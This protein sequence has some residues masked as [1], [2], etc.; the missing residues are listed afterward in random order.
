MIKRY[1]LNAMYVAGS[2]H[3]GLGM[4]ANTYLEGTYSE[5][6][7]DITL[8]EEGMQKLLLQ[9]SY[10]GGIVS[11]A[12][13]ETPGSIH[14]DG[15]LG[16]ALVH[17]YGAGFDN[18]DLFVCCVVG[19]GEAETGPLAAS[20]HSNKFINLARDEAVLPILHLNGY[21]IPNPTVLARLDD[22]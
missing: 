19:D 13:S 11:Y 21:K 5:F 1:D 6:Y 14:E 18:L 12:A 17:A 4:V 15:E 9:F 7:S 10:P 22:R 2:G 8:D 16:D 20:W 3:G